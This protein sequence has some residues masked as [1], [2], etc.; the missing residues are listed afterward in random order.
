MIGPLDVL[1]LILDNG[2]YEGKYTNNHKNVIGYLLDCLTT[3][4]SL[5]YHIEILTDHDYV[6]VWT[7]EKWEIEK[8]RR[9]QTVMSVST[10]TT[11]KKEDP[12][13][14]QLRL[15][16]E[17]ENFVEVMKIKQQMKERQSV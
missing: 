6:R 11:K 10:A 1:N 3:D 8:V 7:A 12:L 16:I 14:A 2:H 4:P 17:G 13:L 5:P 15:A 9:L